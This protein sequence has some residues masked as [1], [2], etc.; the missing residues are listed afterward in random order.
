MK[1]NRPGKLGYGARMRAFLWALPVVA[2]LGCGTVPEPMD[3]GSG[4]G[5]GSTGGG[6]GGGSPIDAGTDAGSGGGT[7]DSGVRMHFSTDVVPLVGSSSS[8]GTCHNWTHAALVGNAT[9]GT[10]G[11]GAIVTPGDGANSLLVKKLEGTAGCG[12]QMP[13]GQ[14]PYDGVRI[15]IIRQWIDQGALDN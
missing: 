11:R 9:L 4:G 7:A 15:G 12:G 8:C 3:A 13:Q 6:T 5:G 2:L 1:G 14:A 10:C